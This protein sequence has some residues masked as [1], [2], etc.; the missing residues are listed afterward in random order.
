MALLSWRLKLSDIIIVGAG[1]AAGQA[2]AS[3]RQEGFAGAITILGDEPHIPY[4]RPPLSKQYLAGEQGLDR[5]YLRPEKFYAGK[6]INVRPGVRVERIDRTAQ[7]LTT[8]SGETLAYDKL[9]LAT[10]SRPRQLKLPGSELEG[11]HYLR[12]IA[13]VDV[14][15]ADMAPGKRVVVVD[16][17]RNALN[18]VV[19]MLGLQLG[20]L[21]GGVVIVE[22]IFSWPGIGLYAFSSFQSFDYNAIMAITVL[23]TAGF[24]LVNALVGQIYPLLDP[25][26]K[27]AR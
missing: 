24:V 12:T 11:V 17:L 23:A 6:D 10:G 26:I 27:E 2:A 13:D 9:L 4:Q 8:A 7:T 19:T 20:W 22:V 5:V 3:L 14:I 1:H 15:K 16:A 25:R 18:P 21:L